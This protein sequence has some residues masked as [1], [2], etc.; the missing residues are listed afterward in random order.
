MY[1]GGQ[2]VLQLLVV[3][4]WMRTT[5]TSQTVEINE[6]LAIHSHRLGQTGR[7]LPV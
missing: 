6:C 4:D 7:R 1:C 3:P 5:L 2:L